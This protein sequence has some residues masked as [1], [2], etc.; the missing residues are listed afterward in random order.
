MHYTS[1]RRNNMVLK[2]FYPRTRERLSSHYK[3]R[4]EE[5]LLVSNYLLFSQKEH[6]I[7]LMITL[8]WESQTLV[9]LRL[10]T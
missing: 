3:Q 5:N 1:P 7:S 2:F 8:V 9:Y 10:H 6:Q 4:F